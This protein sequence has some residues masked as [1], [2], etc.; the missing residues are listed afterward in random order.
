MQIENL[1]FFLH[2]NRLLMF[3]RRHIESRI[4]ELCQKFP[5][6]SVTG[7]RQSGK[8]TLLRELFPNYTYVSLENPDNQDFA[9]K[10]PKRFLAILLAREQRPR[11]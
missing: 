11:N 4:L 3:V 1:I 7:P 2:K 9:I 8:T 10:D 6:I 5:I